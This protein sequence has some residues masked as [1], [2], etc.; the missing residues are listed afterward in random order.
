MKGLVVRTDRS[1]IGRARGGTLKASRLL[2]TGGKTRLSLAELPPGSVLRSV[3]AVPATIDGRQ[4]LRVTLTPEAAAGQPD[5]DYIDQ[6]TFVI[7]PVPF[8]DGR[9]EVDI[10]AGLTDDAPE[11]ARGF[12]GIAFR[13][14]PDASAFESVYVR[15]LNGLALAPAPPRDARALQYF[16]YP[17][18]PYH[19]LRDELPSR[20]FEAGADIRPDAWLTLGVDVDDRRVLVSVNGDRRLVVEHGLAEPRDGSLGLWVDIGTDAYFADLRVTRR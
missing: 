7:L 19:R 2:V 17:E 9:L 8:H 3:T 12:A 16:A 14:A 15:P 11:Y 20:V 10:R 13:I 6:P 4:A 1:G 18:W 5:V